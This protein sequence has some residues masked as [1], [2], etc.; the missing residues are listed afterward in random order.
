MPSPAKLLLPTTSNP[1]KI[2]NIVMKKDEV[3]NNNDQL[4]LI[5]KMHAYVESQVAFGFGLTILIIH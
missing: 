4:D 2:E 3:E 5:D 1:S